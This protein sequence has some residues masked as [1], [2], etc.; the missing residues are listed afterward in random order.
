MHAVH[1]P[2][3]QCRPPWVIRC[4]GH[5][6]AAIA[7]A[8]FDDAPRAAAL[9]GVLRTL[10][11]SAQ[12][13]ADAVIAALE[14]AAAADPGGGVGLCHNDAQVANF[15]RDEARGG[16]LTLIDYDYSDTNFVCYDLGN[17]LCECCFD[18]ETPAA[19][20][21][22][23]FHAERYP[24]VEDEAAFVEAYAA[25]AVRPGVGGEE[26]AGRA[27]PSPGP[28]TPA[29]D[30]LRRQA[31]IAVLA[32]HLLWALWGVLMERALHAAQP[33]HAHGGLDYLG[34]AEC[35]ARE[36]ARLRDA[37]LAPDASSLETPLAHL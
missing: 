8:S 17:V 27:V 12:G 28:R 2:E 16:A 26:G 1:V 31:R 10:G 14:A 22:Y 21:G 3:A 32:S 4:L 11:G 33:S 25:A 6:A 34:Y 7:A 37:L 19:P 15:L 29:L 18:Y 9:A 24:S 30:V 20:A 13:A 5:T 23:I 35:R 36:F